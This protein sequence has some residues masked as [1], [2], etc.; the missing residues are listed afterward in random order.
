MALY[1]DNGHQID[2]ILPQYPLAEPVAACALAPERAAALRQHFPH[3]EV[4]PDLDTL[5]RESTAELVSLCTP[6][7]QQQAADAIR[8]MRA[9]RHVY[10]EKPA[11]LT[12]DA[13]DAI[14][15]T[16]R[17]TG[18]RFH[19]MADTVFHAPFYALRELVTAGRL[20][21]VT[22]VLVQKSYPYRI[23]GALRPAGEAVDGGLTLQVGIH[24]L[25]MAE[26]C[27]GLRLCTV[28]AVE[29]KTAERTNACAM[30]FC[31]DDGA[32]GTATVNYCNPPAFGSWGNDSIRIFGTEGMAE[33]TDNGRRTHLYIGQQDLGELPD[34]P[35]PDFFHA[36]LRE[37][38]FEEPMPISLE[39]ELHPLRMA[40]RAKKCCETAGCKS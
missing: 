14:L 16:S 10:A 12:E 36:V 4:Y 29:A 32:V 37:I 26:H 31:Y 38:L 8:V 21:R 13:L 6:I 22:Q 30:L 24:A 9:G 34:L 17:Q 19:E 23:A 2:R 3:L 27:T 18:C 20:G 5:L 25:R 11:A 39:E 33:I 28:R 7:R 40:L 35:A 1:G 15:Q